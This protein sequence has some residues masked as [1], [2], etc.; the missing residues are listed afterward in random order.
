MIGKMLNIH[1]RLRYLWPS[2]KY[3]RAFKSHLRSR[4]VKW[5]SDD[6]VILL[7]AFQAPSNI[8]A[9]SIF[10]EVLADRSSQIVA[11]ESTWARSVRRNYSRLKYLASPLSLVA[12]R[13]LLVT[14]FR[15]RARR[16][17][18]AKAQCVLESTKDPDCFERIEIN[19]IVIGDL[20][21]DLYTRRTSE[22][23]LDF[24]DARLED[25][26]AE[27]I[28]YV[29]F[30][31]AYFDRF[32]VKAVCIS[33]SVYHL[34]ILSRIAISRNVPSYQVTA[35]SIHYLSDKFP[36]AYTENKNYPQKFNQF[37]T[38][39]QSHART[40]AAERLDLRFS[41]RVGIDMP[42]T[43]I[44]AYGDGALVGETPR[45][46]QN[47]KNLKVLVATHDFFDSPHSFGYNLYPDFLIWMRRLGQLSQQ[48]NYDWYI[49]THPVIQGRGDEILEDFISEFP[50]FT[51]LPASTNHHQI[52]S[53]GIDVALTVYGTIG[54]EYPALGVPAIAAS[55]NGPHSAYSFCYTPNTREDYEQTI[56]NLRDNLYAPDASQVR[57][58]YFLHYIYQLKTW[59][60]QDYDAY[61]DIVG[62][63]SGSM[64]T[65]AMGEYVE[66]FSKT[67][68][69][70]TRLALVN[71]IHS[72]DPRLNKSHFN[73]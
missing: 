46:I 26:L 23:T 33:H 56:L 10:A 63:Y 47:S 29:R 52:I 70:R 54:M 57:E 13:K 17:A 58:Y 20:V 15:N 7:E 68:D 21:Y 60:Y 53:E 11:F 66:S 28:G 43:S 19:G 1:T 62:G 42:G 67:F 69:S 50:N 31:Q 64:T 30:W 48:V 32:D 72:R 14:R 4:R 9:L 41:G 36:M 35:E 25:T 71:F 61:L 49:K 44:S 65:R 39:E 22:P 24:S 34:G 37:S 8:V 40:L 5:Q 27:C 6:S 45:M 55:V 51:V 16:E 38:E 2:D 18:A 3:T 12:N 73:V 59:V